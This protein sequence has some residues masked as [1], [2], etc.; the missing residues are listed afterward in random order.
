MGTSAWAT[1]MCAVAASWAV[2]RGTMKT[3]GSGYVESITYT[4][5][6]TYRTLHR[7]LHHTVQFTVHSDVYTLAASETMKPLAASEW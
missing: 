2:E 3:Q 7:T 6:R 4:Q 5:G 1:R